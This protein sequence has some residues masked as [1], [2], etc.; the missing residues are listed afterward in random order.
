MAKWLRSRWPWAVLLLLAMGSFGGQTHLLGSRAAA[1]ALS[2]WS[3]GDG[4]SGIAVRL[5]VS[6]RST[7][8]GALLGGLEFDLTPGWKTYW[9]SPGAAGI[10]PVFDFTKSVGVD[11]VEVLYPAPER[12]EDAYGTA[13]IYGSDVML[14]L[15]IWP[16]TP[17]TAL[18]LHV[19]LFAGVCETLCVP[20]QAELSALVPATRLVDPALAEAIERAL[21]LVPKRRTAQALKDAHDVEIALLPLPASLKRPYTHIVQVSGA[22]I[23]AHVDLLVEAVSGAFVPVPKKHPPTSPVVAKVGPPVGSQVGSPAGSKAGSKADIQGATPEPG[24]NGGQGG[25][26]GHDDRLGGDRKA[27]FQLDLTR[28][29]PD[30]TQLK[31]TIINR[32][33]GH[34]G[35][36]GAA[37]GFSVETLLDLPPPG[38]RR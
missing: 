19:D 9:R 13:L 2:P 29:P 35:R 28:L 3:K 27:R 32:P 23:G 24:G 25:Q 4:I 14:P 5:V 21:A 20:F 31:V 18:H 16:S 10:A 6:G 30:E 37:A 26:G 38:S 15:K 12:F 36:T 17:K 34:D 22:L 8:D 1:A 11:R 7:E 33:S